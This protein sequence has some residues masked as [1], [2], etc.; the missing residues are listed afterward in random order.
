[1]A[2][3]DIK[4]LN[5][6]WKYWRKFGKI[7]GKI[8]TTI[9]LSIIYYIAVTPTGFIKKILTSKNEPDSYWIDL[10]KQKHDLLESYEQY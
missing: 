1:M 6:I 4:I 8:N 9:I 5:T 10:P 2:L 3:K 7:L